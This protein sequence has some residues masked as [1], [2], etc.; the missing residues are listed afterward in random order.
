MILVKSATVTDDTI[1]G[2]FGPAARDI[3]IKNLRAYPLCK[4]L[5]PFVCICLAVISD[6]YA[7]CFGFIWVVI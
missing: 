3:R 5:L 6:E 2:A 4:T 7:T 1:T